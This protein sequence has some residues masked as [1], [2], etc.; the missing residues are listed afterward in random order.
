M[1][2][3]KIIKP[4]VNKKANLVIGTVGGDSCGKSASPKILIATREWSNKS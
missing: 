2:T 3:E 1:I 4:Y